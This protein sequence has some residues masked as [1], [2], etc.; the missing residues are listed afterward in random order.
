MTLVVLVIAICLLSILVVYRFVRGP[1]VR[2]EEAREIEKLI[3]PVDLAAFRTLID[4][5]EERFL[6]SRLPESEVRSLCRERA[7][8]ALGYVH[9]MA[10]NAALI[11]CLADRASDSADPETAATGR[12]LAVTALR[13]RVRALQAE[14]YLV[15]SILALEL[16]A[17][18][19]N[20]V[21]DY[22]HIH[23][24]A[25]LFWGGAGLAQSSPA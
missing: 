13:F 5:E 7:Q 8:V 18:I 17:S 3:Q 22:E 10:G 15:V 24:G 6:R 20:L 1:A 12:E 16:P 25:S 19:Q 2:F 9:V 23:Q 11:L 21:A 14:F 4:P